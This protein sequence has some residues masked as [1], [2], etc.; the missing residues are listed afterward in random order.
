MCATLW[1]VNFF[2]SIT[3]DTIRFNPIIIKT[4]SNMAPQSI[5]VGKTAARKFQVP[6]K[7]TKDTALRIMES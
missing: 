4:A 7:S 3:L 2:T 6:V 5:Q 1:K